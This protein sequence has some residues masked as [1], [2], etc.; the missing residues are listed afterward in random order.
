M[1][2]ET[3]IFHAA[4]VSPD[5]PDRSAGAR[6]GVRFRAPRPGRTGMKRIRREDAIKIGCA[7]IPVR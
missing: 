6:V 2:G 5:S 1:A 4:R 7:E 3:W